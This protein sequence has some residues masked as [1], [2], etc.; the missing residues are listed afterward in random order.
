MSFIVSVGSYLPDGILT[1]DDLAEIVDTS[2]EWIY[3]RTGIKS[4]HI[5]RQE[6]VEDM[7]VF[8]AQDALKKANLKADQIGLIIGATLGANEITPSLGCSIAKRIGANCPAFDVNAACSGGLYAL[9]IAKSMHKYNP[10][11][12]VAS[13]KLTNYTNWKDRSTCILFGDGAGAVIVADDG[14][15]EI[16]NINLTASPDDNCSLSVDGVNHTDEMGRPA[17][18]YIKMEGQAVYKFATSTMTKELN[19]LLE[20]NNLSTQDISSYILHQANYRIISAIAKKLDVPIEKFYSNIHHTANT[21][22]A[23]V[24]IALDEFL[25][26]NS[27]NTDELMVLGAFGGGFTTGCGILKWK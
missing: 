8:A 27:M 6:T 23:S 14:I 7:A 25:T 9:E 24:F 4:R 12:I 19:K 3:S 21:S 18:S 26:N 5:A 2:D 16:L 10:V 20:E 13:E 22:C 15:A 17:H 1:N 11:L